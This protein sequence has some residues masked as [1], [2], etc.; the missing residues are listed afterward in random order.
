MICTT[1]PTESPIGDLVIISFCGVAYALLVIT[2]EPVVFLSAA[3]CRIRVHPP[4]GAKLAPQSPPLT[5]LAD[6]MME[7]I[8]SGTLLTFRRDSMGLMRGER[9]N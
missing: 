8:V 9:L 2:T 7:L 5:K 6:G 4:P 1:A 3:P